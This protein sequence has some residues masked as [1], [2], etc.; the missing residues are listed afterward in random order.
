MIASIISKKMAAGST[1]ILID[2]PYGPQAKC[3]DLESAKSLK[4]DFETLGKNLGLY[5]YV[6]LSE[7]DQ[8]IGNGIGPA[9]EAK[10][11][12]DILK[13]EPNV[14]EDLKEKILYL[15]GIIIEFDPNVKKGD[16]IKIAKE[17]LESGRAFERFKKIFEAQG[18]IKIFQLLN[19][20]KMNIRN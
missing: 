15:S 18:G 13:N 5:V 7:G 17:I 11:I 16:G 3:K 19:I 2:I 12:L 8:P 6:T 4:Y 14:C 20:K 1:H 10:D 9:L